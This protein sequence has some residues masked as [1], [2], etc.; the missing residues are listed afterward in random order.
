MED[1]SRAYTLFVDV[2]RSVQYM[3]D[4]QEQYMYNQ[5]P[6]AMANGSGAVAMQA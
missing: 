5:V 2:R 1:V 3:M 4:Y 6:Q